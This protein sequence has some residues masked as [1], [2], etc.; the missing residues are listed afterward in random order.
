M[1]SFR[2]GIKQ[3]LLLMVLA[4]LVAGLYSAVL[5][6]PVKNLYSEI[7]LSPDG[8]KLALLG[9]QGLE[10]KDLR[11]GNRI[12]DYRWRGSVISSPWVHP[13]GDRLRFMDD[14]H[15][16]LVRTLFPSP[17]PSVEVIGVSEN[18]RV[19][20][21]PLQT[22]F[23]QV[24]GSIFGNRYICRDPATQMVE[25]VDLKTRKTLSA[26]KFPV[27]SE[28]ALTPD[29]T[30]VYSCGSASLPSK[31]SFW[32]YQTKNLVG[33]I[34]REVSRACFSPDSS[35][36]LIDYASGISLYQLIRVDS[37]SGFT[38][39]F[40]QRWSRE[41]LGSTQQWQFSR[42]GRLIAVSTN[43]EPG[44]VD[45]LDAENGQTI[46]ELRSSYANRLFEFSADASQLYVVPK[47]SDSRIEVWDIA[48]GNLVRSFDANWRLIKAMLYSSLL[49]GWAAIWGCM[50]RRQ[51]MLDGLAQCHRFAETPSGPLD[52]EPLVDSGE[53]EVISGSV[54]QQNVPTTVTAA[55]TMMLIGG[56]FGIL[57]AV[58]PM[59]YFQNGFL[60]NLMPLQLISV[61]YVLAGY[62]LLAGVLA[63]S[64]GT[65]RLSHLVQTTSIM[66]ALNILQLDVLNLALGIAGIALLNQESARRYLQGVVPKSQD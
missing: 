19:G 57:W 58:V 5:R 39:D 51:N 24:V 55:W 41:R 45:L 64:R 35:Y 33:E 4:A 59:F 56:I 30:L 46:R 11:N 49:I 1:S 32:D 48:S 62:G 27:T 38:I 66:Q 3:I 26:K 13:D 8:K 47:N 28:L 14:N 65:G 7:D 15:L 2:F 40:K 60:G 17:M 31:I 53:I 61:R 42:D 12:A 44:K 25:V 37:E 23:P 16:V 29:G 43:H 63:V 18:A 52:D 20:E 36:V 6:Q 9:T 50:S 54:D 10:V 34:N 22:S 21:I